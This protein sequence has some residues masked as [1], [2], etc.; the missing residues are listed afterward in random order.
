ML[1]GDFHDFR[2]NCSGISFVRGYV[3]PA[4]RDVIRF[5]SNKDILVVRCLKKPGDATQEFIAVIF[6]RLPQTM[7]RKMPDNLD[8]NECA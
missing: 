1:T 2:E 7:S 3:S 8:V 4:S 6:E 5:F